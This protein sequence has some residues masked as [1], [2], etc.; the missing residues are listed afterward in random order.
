M[1]MVHK[2][3]LLWSWQM[4]SCQKAIHSDYHFPLIHL[5]HI[6]H[7][8]SQSFILS[9]FPPPSPFL[10]LFAFIRRSIYKHCWCQLPRRFRWLHPGQSSSDPW[11]STD[12]FCRMQCR[13]TKAN[14][15]NSIFNNI[16][17]S[18]SNKCH[19]EIIIQSQK[20]LFPNS[21]DHWK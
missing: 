15:I 3:T 16:I 2:V 7:S 20:H 19:I 13:Q 8:F 21:N 10:E 9:P 5:S 11:P 14:I 4:K 18:I 1:A 6:I 17:N 12:T